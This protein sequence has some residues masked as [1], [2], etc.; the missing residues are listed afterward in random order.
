MINIVVS[1]AA[2]QLTKQ[3]LRGDLVNELISR[4]EQD[5]E[6]FVAFTMSTETQTMIQNYLL[7][8]KQKRKPQR[9]WKF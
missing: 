7:S 1:A 3:Q 2:R 5:I 9:V 4:R 6:D 8:L